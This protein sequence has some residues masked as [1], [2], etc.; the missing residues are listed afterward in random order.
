[1]TGTALVTG[2][3]SG[4]GLALS[5]RLAQRGYRLLWVSLDAEEL[6]AAAEIVR[7]AWPDAQ[8]D[9]LALDLSAPDAAQTVIDWAQSV[10]G[11]D[12]LVN[13][14]GLG[15]YGDSASLPIAAEQSMISV[16]IGALH[17]L[18][19][20]FLAAMAERGGGRIINIASNSAFTPA[21]RLAVYAAT[22]AFVKHYTEAMQQEIEAA[23]LQVQVMTVFPSAVSDTPFKLRANMDR[24]RTFSSFTATTADEVADD[25][26]RGMDADR[27]VVIT[28]AAM[29]RSMLLLKL[30]PA[31]LVRWMT[32]RETM[33][34]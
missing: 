33:R 3:S 26:V 21:P 11:A 20:L 6:G 4:I 1:M 30:A 22:K 27:A 29:R 5:H 17:A 13:N 23:G 18:T 28:G 32:R 2:G 16:N 31:A 25:I 15:V 14:A 34:L 12:L 9:T 19:R 8:I 7:A 24:V 10:G